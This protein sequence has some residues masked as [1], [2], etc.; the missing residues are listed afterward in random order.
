M[1]TKRAILNFI[2]DVVPLI[3]I[4]ILGIFKLKYFIMILGDE[5]LGLY[6]LFTQIMVYVALVDGGLSSAVLFALYKPNTDN[7]TKTMN[8][9]LAGAKKT[10]SLIGIIVFAIAAVVA[11]IIPFFIEGHTFSYMY[12]VFT[13]ILFSLSNVI[14]YFF[15]PYQCLVE[16][17]EKKYIANLALQI[18][19][20]IQNTLEIVFLLSGWSFISIL[21]MHS[22][23]KLLSNV[24]IYLTCCKLYPEVNSKS[25][26]KD[27][28]FTKQVRHLVF[29]KI[30]GLVG[31]NIDVL[32]ISKILGLASVAIYSTYNYIVNM[33]MTIIGKIRGALLAIIGNYLNK[34][35]KQQLV[36]LFLELNSMMF[37]TAT[38]ICVPLVFALDK[39]INIWYEGKI[40]TNICIS[41]AFTLYLLVFIIKQPVVTYITAAGLF[42]ETKICALTDT[43]VNLILSLTLVWIIGIPGVLIATAVAVFIAEYI[44]KGVILYKT[45]FKMEPKKYYIMNIKFFVIMIIDIFVAYVILNSINIATIGKWFVVYI[46]FTIIN[47]I[48]I[49]LVYYILKEVKFLHRIKMIFGGE[50]D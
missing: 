20:I 34:E 4:S 23:I 5:T 11:F 27:F 19:Q 48:V 24:A 8:K 46:L 13:F 36:D 32:I 14:S 47:G 26:E 16:V 45:V 50:K 43:I 38:V 7:D 41:L 39:F 21:F 10:F 22:I 44:M 18:G 28:S 49:L 37:Y 1:K 33:L 17:K 40:S 15:V 42:K 29:H 2:T 6:Q 31:S 35:V 9:I 30:N 3:I 25:K 12:I